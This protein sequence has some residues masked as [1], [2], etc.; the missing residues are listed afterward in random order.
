VFGGRAQL[1]T[2][3]AALAEAGIPIGD[4]FDRMSQ[5][6]SRASRAALRT[7]SQVISK[8]GTLREALTQSGYFKPFEIEIIAAGESSGRLPESFHALAEI[9]EKKKKTVIAY[10]FAMAYPF[11]LMHAA[12]MLPNVA[13]IIQKGAGTY[14]LTVGSWL[15]VFYSLCLMPVIFYLILRSNAGTG[16]IVDRI[17][18]AIPLIGSVVKKTEMARCITVLA[19][20]YESGTPIIKAVEQSAKI[21]KNYALKSVWERVAQK[22]VDK[23]T[24]ATAIAAEPLVPPMVIDF[25]STGESSGQ[26]DKLLHQSAATLEEEAKN[27]RRM[28]MGLASTLAFLVAAGLAAFQIISFYANL[29]SS[30]PK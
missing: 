22:M 27:T 25:I 12:I 17:A 5:T 24:L 21:S 4:G 20:L 8:G 19:Y 6:L 7:A 1:Y 15:L 16:A 3:L 26:L 13:I 30:L 18:L 14:F 29:Y 9:C 10:V 23:E 11:F 28:V 2:R